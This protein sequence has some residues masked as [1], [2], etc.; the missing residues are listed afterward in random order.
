[1]KDR[2]DKSSASQENGFYTVTLLTPRR[3]SSACSHGETRARG[4]R[5]PGDRAR[6]P[7]IGE[8]ESDCEGAPNCGRPRLSA[9]IDPGRPIDHS[10]CVGIR[11]KSENLPLRALPET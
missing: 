9:A 4:K 11:R 6:L 7:H 3:L 5:I 10:S 2:E 8:Y 1:M